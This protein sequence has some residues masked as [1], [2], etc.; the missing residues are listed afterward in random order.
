MRIRDSQ[1][2]GAALRQARKRQ[3][4]TQAQLAEKAGLRQHTISL[5]EG[6]KPYTQI[7]VIFAMMAALGLDATLVDRADTTPDLE[8]LF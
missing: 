3:G 5:V 8:D 2:I 6:G 1:Q 7:R 4:L